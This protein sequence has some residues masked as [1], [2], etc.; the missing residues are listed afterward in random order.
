MFII[1]GQ[2][3]P[4]GLHVQMDFKTGKKQAKKMANSGKPTIKRWDAGEN[5]GKFLGSCFRL[6]ELCIFESKM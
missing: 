5:M 4:P 3:I 2:K 6:K 1:A